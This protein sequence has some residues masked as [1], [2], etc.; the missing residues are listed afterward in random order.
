VVKQYTS[1]GDGVFA[2]LPNDLA[3]STT[4]G[5]LVRRC[6][7]DRQGRLRWAAIVD[8]RGD[9]HL[10]RFFTLWHEI[11]HCLTAVE[12][13]EL[14]LYHRASIHATAKDSI[15]TVTDLIAGDFA[16]YDPLFNPVLADEVAQAGRLTFAGVERVRNIYCEEASFKSTLYACVTR[17]PSPLMWLE[18][19]LA[20]KKAELAALASR[21]GEII[22]S[23]PPTPALRVTES[24]RNEAA[25][26]IGLYIP[27]KMRVPESSVI[28]TAFFGS[29]S[30]QAREDL[31]EW[32]SRGRYLD[33]LPIHVEARKGFSGV[34]AL[35]TLLT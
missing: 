32:S 29:Y 1:D 10:C 23:A 28:F 27:K 31:G 19:D 24:F 6:Q 18:A 34:S 22:P 2:I 13:Y 25:V 8:C 21:Q 20:Y 12:Q 11:A 16:F 9:K 26:D 33:Y 14:P 5:V 17:L 15:E 30:G 7:N 35:I 3:P 4:L